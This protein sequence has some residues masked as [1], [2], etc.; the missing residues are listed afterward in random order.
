MKTKT[1]ITLLIIFILLV[2]GTV[3]ISNM[4]TV[5]GS[6]G[7]GMAGPSKQD[8]DNRVVVTDAP[9]QVVFRLDDHRFLTLENYIACDKSG[10]VYYNDTLLGI[11]TRLEV[12][13]RDHYEDDG[14]TKIKNYY[15]GDDQIQLKDVENGIM[16]YKGILLYDAINGALAFPFVNN[17]WEGCTNNDGCYQGALVSLDG[18]ETFYRKSYERSS[19]YPTP[20]TTVTVDNNAYLVGYER[21]YGIKTVPFEKKK[22]VTEDEN[23][24]FDKNTLN[25]RKYDIRLH[26]DN[27]IKPSKIRFVTPKKEN[28]Q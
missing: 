25:N 5:G 6:F 26:C 9:A 8:N 16:A 22:D 3:V 4:P 17:T 7:Y 24:M 12:Y 13:N 14:I 21:S 15:A 11:K 18:G 10:Q 2:I 27:N 1:L 19:N 23:A 28:K 20:F